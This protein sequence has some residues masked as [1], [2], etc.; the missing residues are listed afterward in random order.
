MAVGRV[1]HIGTLGQ[2]GRS[3]GRSAANAQSGTTGPSGSA[4]AGT[5]GRGRE[6]MTAPPTTTGTGTGPAGTSPTSTGG[7]AQRVNASVLTQPI[8]TQ[9]I[10]VQPSPVTTPTAVSTVANASN[11]A[12]T[13]AS[14]VV[15]TT[16]SGGDLFSTVGGYLDSFSPIV[17]G[18]DNATL[19]AVVGVTA[20]VLLIVALS[21]KR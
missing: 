1:H 20:A 8:F 17:P 9:P 19:V 2:A 10:I 15:G 11:S 16:G 3:P 21:R 12:L 14:G 7:F 5:V 18:I 13:Q 4:T 6:T